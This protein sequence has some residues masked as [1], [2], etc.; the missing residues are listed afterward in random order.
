M[1]E[2]AN[3]D[4]SAPDPLSESTP[5]PDNDLPPSKSTDRLVSRLAELRAQ[6]EILAPPDQDRGRE[7]IERMLQAQERVATLEQMLARAREREDSLTVQ[8]IR[9]QAAI[10]DSESRLAEMS[11]IAAR[12]A[13]SEAARREEET[14]AAEANR[15]L[16]LAQAEA[17]ARRTEIERLRSR[18][19][20]LETDLS[21][22]AREVAA[23]TVA[24]AEASRTERE[25]NE[26]RDR[27]SAERRLAAEDRRRAAEANLRAA[28]LQS[29][30][31]AAER[32]IVKLTNERGPSETEPEAP[33]KVLG[34]KRTQARTEAR[35]GTLTEAGTEA[36][37]ESP[38]ESPA[39]APSE[40][41]WTTLQ[42]ASF[43]A[44]GS[45]EL[46]ERTA[47]ENDV[48]DLTQETPDP[49]EQ[50]TANGTTEPEDVPAASGASQVKGIGL[51]GRMLRGRQHDPDTGSSHHQP[52]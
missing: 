47:D 19:S 26:A 35:T 31:L 52:E 28:E 27:A 37:T 18:C 14:V 49:V 46:V 22:L 51:F 23:A 16:T 2:K 42:R 3:D 10:A 13:T 5:Y 11:A 43:A 36:R 39:K 21:R 44:A 12:V 38:A 15:K 1:D 4:G 34:S 8:S 32:R 48:I 50:E 17:D 9:D 6:V 25:R 24:R 29:Q 40:A 30:L 45:A 7:A 41:P 33:P 20:E